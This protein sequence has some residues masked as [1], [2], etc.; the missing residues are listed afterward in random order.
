MKIVNKQGI[1]QANHVMDT[2]GLYAFALGLFGLQIFLIGFLQRIVYCGP[3]I[4]CM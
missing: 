1:P 4:G 2:M 3:S